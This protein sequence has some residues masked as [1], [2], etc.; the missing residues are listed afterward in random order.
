[1]LLT[2]L[3]PAPPTPQTM[4]CGFN[5]LSWGAFGLIVVPASLVR[6]PPLR[7]NQRIDQQLL[8]HT[9]C[10]SGLLLSF[11][12]R[13]AQPNLATPHKQ[14]IRLIGESRRLR[15]TFPYQAET[16]DGRLFSP[17]WPRVHK[18]V[19]RK[20]GRDTSQSPIFPW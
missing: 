5:S 11:A 9:A 1:M 12:A 3:P 15:L 17:C 14:S 13:P 10:C 20:R 7:L 6:R 16:W 19:C 2:A 4:M 8:S 18:D